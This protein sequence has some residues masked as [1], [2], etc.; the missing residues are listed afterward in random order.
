LIVEDEVRLAQIVARVL[1]SERFDVEIANDGERGLDAALTGNFD[2]LI[3][4]RLLPKRDGLAL[5]R[6]VRAEGLATPVLILT[7]LGDVPERVVGLDAGADDYLGKPFAF[8]ELLA[9]LRALLRRS[10]RPIEPE[11]VVIGDLVVDLA[12]RSVTRQ[13]RAVALSPREWALLEQFVRH[14]GRVLDRDTLLARVWGYDAE[15]RGNTVDLYVHYLRRK[16]GDDPGSPLIRTVR[17][18]GYVLPTETGDAAGAGQ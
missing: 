1:R 9:R 10:N 15:P 4:D 3:V 18:T 11:R 17:G 16:L 2:A 13:G 7:A 5:V 8:D 6:A 14:R 12:E